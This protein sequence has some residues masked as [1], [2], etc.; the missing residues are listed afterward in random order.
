MSNDHDKRSKRCPKLGHDITFDYCQ[1][2]ANGG[3]C[4][5][6]LNCWWEFFNVHEFLKRQAPEA[7]AELEARTP[8]NRVASL[9]DMIKQAQARAGGSPGDGGTTA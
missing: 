2:E 6:I 1:T 8:Q 5:G 9:A 7:L 4:N 3:L